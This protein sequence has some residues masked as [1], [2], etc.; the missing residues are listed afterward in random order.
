MPTDVENIH[1]LYLV[2]TNDG[3]P[4][5]D[6]TAVGA[7]MELKPGAV[8]KRW[9]RLK[10]S[11]E[12]G[13]TPATSCY[14]FLWLCV[15]HNKRDKPPNWADIATKCNTTQ[16]AASKRYS[17]MKQAFEQNAPPPTSVP[18]SPVKNT[19]TKAKTAPSTPKNKKT[20]PAEEDDDN[21]AIAVTPTPT[22]KRKRATPAKKK[23]AV[24]EEET[25][26]KS[27]MN[28]YED[29]GQEEEVNTKRV[30]SVKVI[31][32]PKVKGRV[33]I[34]QEEDEGAIEVEEVIKREPSNDEEDT[35]A[36]TF[37]DAQEHVGDAFSEPNAPLSPTA[38][39][40][41]CMPCDCPTK[42]LANILLSRSA[43]LMTAERLELEEMVGVGGFVE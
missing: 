15:K 2:L 20:A 27:D 39:G 12:K 28:D 30:K 14:P 43:H 3:A 13:E 9:S 19:P 22:P 5:I 10:Q 24:I 29:D 7:A 38:C 25:K 37:Y 32:K 23:T 36:D 33:R 18:R 8:S 16:G 6:W 42:Q 1:Y 31:P 17:R 4:S 26:N 11:M 41:T 34:E 40:K 21:E 35:D